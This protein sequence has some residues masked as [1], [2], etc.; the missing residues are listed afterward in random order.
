MIAYNSAHPDT[1]LKYGQVL[2]IQ[3]Q[4]LDLYG[5]EPKYISDRATD[6]QLAKVQ[7]IDATMDSNN[8]TALV[9]PANGGAGIAAKSGYPSVIVPAGYLTTA[10]PFGITFTGKAYSEATL[11]TLA[12]AFEQATKVRQPPGSALRLLPAASGIVSG[13]LVN[14]ASGASG[15]VA[16]G[17]IVAIPG[18]GLGPAQAAALRVTDNKHIDTIAGGTRVLFDAIHLAP[19][20]AH[21]ADVGCTRRVARGPSGRAACRARA[22]RGS[23]ARCDA[24]GCTREGSG[25]GGVVLSRTPERDAV[26]IVQ[27]R[28]VRVH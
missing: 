2:A 28:V 20:H 11:I 25:R 3:S 17:E 9:F 1:A 18:S 21:D 26:E 22:A 15:P 10:A 5:D 6:L 8:L 12:Y 24:R 4:A 19:V 13:P 7:G 23:L 27:Q 14:Y 16:P